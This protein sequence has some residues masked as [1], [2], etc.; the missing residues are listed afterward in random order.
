MFGSKKQTPEE[1]PPVDPKTRASLYGMAALY[2]AYL[3]YKTAW[4]YLTN[5]P[6]GP[7][8]LQFLLGVLILGGGLVFLCIMTWKMAHAPRPEEPA[9]SEEED[10]PES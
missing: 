6:Y 4:P 5:D 1:R 10:P 3:L 9:S 2:L 8:T 7:T